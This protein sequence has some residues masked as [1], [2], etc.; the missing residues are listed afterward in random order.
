MSIE[1]NGVTLP[2][3][4]SE[5]LESYP[6]AVITALRATDAPDGTD[7]AYYLFSAEK[8]GYFVSADMT[9]DT[10]HYITFFDSFMDNTYAMGVEGGFAFKDSNGN[11][12]GQTEWDILDPA[13]FTM[14]TCFLTTDTY[15]GDSGL[16]MDIVWA[17]HDVIEA[18]GVNE[19]TGELLTGEIYFAR[20][21]SDPN[22]YAPKS[23]FD[24]MA[25]Q[26]MRI[27]GTS[28]KLNTEEMLA[29]LK[30]AIAVG[31]YDSIVRGG[32]GVSTLNISG[33]LTS[34]AS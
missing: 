19:E 24:G 26:V 8:P 13:K 31:P 12:T 30:D 1:V 2:D 22:Y 32:G 7:A 20:N 27:T 21:D 18:T 23:W 6:Y 17:N 10:W 5:V 25:R 14:D 28:D 34:S 33:L 16:A 15:E 9:G 11:A 4:P 3:I 29:G